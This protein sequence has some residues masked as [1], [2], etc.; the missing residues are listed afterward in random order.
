MTVIY[1][2]IFGSPN[3]GVYCFACEGLAAVPTSTPKGKKRRIAEC[4]KVDVCEVNIAGSNLLG[5]MLAGNSNGLALPH[6][7]M[8]HELETL[9]ETSI[10]IK[11]LKERKTALGNLILTNDYGA[12]VDPTFTDQ[13]V[14]T[15]QEI[16][17]VEVVRGTIAGLPY[18]GSL[19]VATNKGV[20]THPMITSEEQ[21]VISEVLKVK[22]EPCT[23]NGGVPY[24]KSGLLATSHGAVAGPLTQ[25][26]ELMVI[27]QT[28][29]L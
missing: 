26:K 1:S 17:Q 12:I 19:G 9:K 15:L 8:D 16:L 10:N 2:D 25:G 4:L 3:I 24:V 11:T 14:K 22:V 23:V 20:I 7:V 13:T 5:I 29:N 27:S 18:V 28:M 6:T 21:K